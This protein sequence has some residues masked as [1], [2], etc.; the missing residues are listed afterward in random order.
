MSQKNEDNQ[1]AESSIQQYHSY[2]QGST[3]SN[4]S[5]N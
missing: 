2:S 1:E 3:T 4:H 5:S